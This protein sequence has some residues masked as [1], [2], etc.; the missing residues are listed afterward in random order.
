[1]MG[2]IVVKLLILVVGV[3]AVIDVLFGG[4]LRDSLVKPGRPWPMLPRSPLARSCGPP[5]QAIAPVAF[6]GLSDLL[7]GTTTA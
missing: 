2:A 1:M 4:R 7:N 3:G 5:I 6:G